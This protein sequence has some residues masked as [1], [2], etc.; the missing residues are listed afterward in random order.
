MAGQT[1]QVLPVCRHLIMNLKERRTMHHNDVCCVGTR[2]PEV[3][4]VLAV[5]L[6]LL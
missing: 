6:D 1:V 5:H 3:K 2:A 4:E